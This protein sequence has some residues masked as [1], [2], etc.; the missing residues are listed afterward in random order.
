VDS[1]SPRVAQFYDA[2]PFPGKAN[3]YG[4]WRAIAP[5]LLTGL[6]I[7]SARLAGARVLDLGCG[8]GEFARS[9]HQ[10]GADV[11]AIDLS[12]QALRAAQEND[13]AAG[14]AGVEYRQADVFALPDLG[15]FDYVFSLGVLHHTDDPEGAFN[16]LVPLVR[17]GGTL[18]IGLY[19]SV[20]R[21]HIVAARR[22]LRFL[23]RGSDERGVVLAKRCLGRVL[24]M[25]VGRENVDDNARIADLLVHPH[26]RP[27]A[28]QTTLRWLDRSGFRV[29]GSDPSHDV[30]S[31]AVLRRL[32]T[33]LSRRF[34]HVLIQLRW[35][36]WNADYYVIAGSR[37]TEHDEHP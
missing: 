2:Y 11:V 37:V 36:A 17:P 15:T 12:A 4:P 31:Y 24:H 30:R 6:G 18:V 8:T 33:W 21:I 27:V 5:N 10:L 28:L 25:F 20:S 16:R 34:G 3:A 32:P 14:I 1:V 29:V 9:F 22:I 23:S 13:A 35:I 26:E 19:S 7:D